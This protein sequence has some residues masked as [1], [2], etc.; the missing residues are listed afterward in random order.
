MAPVL[1]AGFDCRKLPGVEGHGALERG[2]RSTQTWPL[3]VTVE[4]GKS[5][6]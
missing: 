4:L 5:L 1:W 6:L 2:L 3:L